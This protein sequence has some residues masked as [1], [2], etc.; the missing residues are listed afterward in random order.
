MSIEQISKLHYLKSGY[1]YRSIIDLSFAQTINNKFND[2]L[3]INSI[4]GIPQL[5]RERIKGGT[6]ISANWESIWYNAKS[7]YGFRQT[8]FIFANMTYIRS[9]GSNFT[10]GDIYSSIGAGSRIRNENLV[11]GTVELKGFYFPRTNLQLSPWNISVTTNL[12]FKYNSN[13]LSKPDFVPVN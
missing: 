10:S 11:F 13:L 3:L 2:A 5:T 7:Y 4:Y 12:R 9:M 1:K 6:R 8:P